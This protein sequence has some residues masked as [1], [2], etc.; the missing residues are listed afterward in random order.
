MTEAGPTPFEAVEHLFRLWL[1]R[2]RLVLT[3]GR[4]PAPYEEE[5]DTA[6]SPAEAAEYG[7]FPETF[8]GPGGR[9]HPVAAERF[10]IEDPDETSDGPLHASWGVPDD[11][12]EQV[13]ELIIGALETDPRGLDRR[14]RAL[15]GYLAGL[16]AAGGTDLLH[17]TAAA[18][19]DGAPADGE[20]HLLVRSGAGTVRLALA[21]APAG[22]GDGDGAD[23]TAE[24]RIACA[25]TL[26]GEFLRINNN[27]TVAFEAAFGTHGVGLDTADPDAAFRTGWAGD[28]HWPIA[29]EGDDEADDVLWAVDA[30]A[31]KA[32]L[33]ESESNMVAKARRGTL[34]WEFD[35]AAPEIPGGELVSWLARDLLETVLTEAT[36]APGTPPLLAYAKN[37]PLDSVLYGEGYSCLLLVGAE[38][39]ALVQVG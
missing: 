2:W 25:A 39:T 4:A 14:G 29:E 21:P 30:A 23:D 8:P 20:L 6:P 33:A 26:L 5:W 28:G 34:L 18:D 22:A 38:R 19:P 16:V 37:L 24:H 27:D 36:G 3:A 11:G 15:A 31:L 9:R 32:A 1:P 10:G 17:I 13:F 12:A 35:S 7:A